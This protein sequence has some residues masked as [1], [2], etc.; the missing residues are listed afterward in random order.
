MCYS[1]FDAKDACLFISD[2][3]FRWQHPSLCLMT[4]TDE[5]VMLTYVHVDGCRSLQVFISRSAENLDFWN[6]WGPPLHLSFLS[7]THL[8]LV[9]ASHTSPSCITIIDLL[10]AQMHY[11]LCFAA[12]NYMHQCQFRF[13]CRTTFNVVAARCTRATFPFPFPFPFPFFCASHI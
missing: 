7:A 6:T 2:E 5:K 1:F 10:S 9:S 12:K 11:S 8:D 3:S 4:A 13:R